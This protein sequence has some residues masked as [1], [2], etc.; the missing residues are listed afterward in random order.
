MQIE[1]YGKGIPPEKL[2]AVQSGASGFGIR[3]MR[4]R[5]R[6]YGG[7]LQVTSSSSGTRVLV[8]IP[9][10]RDQEPERIEPARVAS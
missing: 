2:A 3:A 7:E 1:D 4:E 9:Q 8:T 5:V 10:T 6:P